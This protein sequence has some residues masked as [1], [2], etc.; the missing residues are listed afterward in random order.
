MCGQQVRM[1]LAARPTKIPL[2]LNLQHVEFHDHCGSFADL[3]NIPCVANSQFTADRY[4]EAYGVEPRVVHPLMDAR[5]YRTETTR[6]N[7]TFISPHPLKG[8]DL[9]IA[10]ARQCPEIPFSF[11]ESWRLSPDERRALKGKL[12]DAPNVKLRAPVRDMREIYGKC[13]IL[14]APSRWE[15]AYGRVASEAQFNTRGCF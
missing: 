5:N 6:E 7:V 13:R 15:E 10:V 3:G 1:A 11:V 2:L 9:A 14:L 4:R 8:V 12:A